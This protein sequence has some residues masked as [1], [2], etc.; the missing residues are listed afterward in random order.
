MSR[1]L[2][3]S[4]SKALFLSAALL[5][6]VFGQ[7]SDHGRPDGR[8]GDRG[9]FDRGQVNDN[10]NDHARPDT[11]I[12]PP[13]PVNGGSNNGF[14]GGNRG[15]YQGNGQSGQSNPGYTERPEGG[16]G[17]NAPDNRGNGRQARGYE[18]RGFESRG[19]E[20]RGF[21]PRGYESRR[22]VH[23]G[24]ARGFG[25]SYDR[26]YDRRFYRARYVSRF[27]N[28]REERA[29]RLYLAERRWDYRAWDEC[30]SYDQDDYWDWRDV[31]PDRVL[32]SFG[33]GFGR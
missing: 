11:Q 32:F 20:S 25:R 26:D 33:I 9:Q 14:N 29:Y 3:G 1:N 12:R 5:T 24:Y 30:E 22:Y 27:W 21:E 23:G 19:F 4:F 17:Y 13:A 10:R 2:K 31:H 16:R 6:P 18:T 7:M 28:E 8:T 15:W